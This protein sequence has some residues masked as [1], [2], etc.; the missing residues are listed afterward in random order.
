[1]QNVVPK[2]INSRMYKNYNVSITS[3]YVELL[4]ANYTIRCIDVCDVNNLLYSFFFIN[5]TLV[6]AYI[7]KIQIC[8][9]HNV[10]I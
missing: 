10:E 9:I 3:P 5:L 7:D 2:S 8:N 4:I 6:L 1:M